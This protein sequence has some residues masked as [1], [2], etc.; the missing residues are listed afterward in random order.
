MDID[1][2]MIT[3]NNYFLHSIKEICIAKYVSDKQ[4]TPTSSPH[5]IYQY[6]DTML[7]YPPKKIAKRN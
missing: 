3:V 2:E 1:D 5:E 4:L 6:S 7:K